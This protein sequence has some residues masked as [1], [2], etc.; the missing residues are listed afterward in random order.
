[1]ARPEEKAAAGRRDELGKRAPAREAGSALTVQRVRPALA[2]A[3]QVED[4]LLAD[5][6]TVDRTRDVP[7]VAYLISSYMAEPIQNGSPIQYL[8]RV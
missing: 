2:V 8:F 4:L 5:L 7:H 3:A 6:G 1:M